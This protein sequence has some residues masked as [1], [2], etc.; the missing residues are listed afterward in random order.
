[1]S[2]TGPQQGRDDVEGR[3]SV[4]MADPILFEELSVHN[5][6]RLLNGLSSSC[7]WILIPISP[8]V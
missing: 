4:C 2:I 3:V 5:N 6:I 8:L 7:K 1:M